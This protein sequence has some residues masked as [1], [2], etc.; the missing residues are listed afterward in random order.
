MASIPGVRF[1]ITGASGSQGLL[2]PKSSWRAYFLPRGGNASQDSAGTLIT[3]DSADVASRFTVNDWV[4]AGSLPANIRQVSVVDGNSMSVSGAAVTV[5]ENDRVFLIGLTQPTVTGGSATYTTPNTVIRERDDDAAGVFANSMITSDS[6]GLIQGFG[7]ASLYDVII[8]DGN[9]SHQGSIVDLEFGMVQGVS[10]VDPAIFGSTVTFLGN[11][12]G[13]STN[14]TSSFGDTATF[15]SIDAKNINTVIY[16]HK[17]ATG[18][19]GTV[20]DPWTGWDT[21]I[22]AGVSWS[23]I[24]VKFA[25][26][27]FQSDGGTLFSGEFITLEGSGQSNTIIFLNS[28]SATLFA[29]DDKTANRQH[30]KFADF[31]IKPTVGIST[32]SS[33]GIDMSGM[34]ESIVRDV[35]IDNMAIGILLDKLNNSGPCFYNHIET[36][37]F[38]SDEGSLWTGA[39]LLG[40]ANSNTF[41]RCRFSRSQ[42]IIGEDNDAHGP[43]DI[44]IDSCNF[45]GA[46]GTAIDISESEGLIR[47]KSC[48]FEN[49]SGSG[50]V[51]DDP[52]TTNLNN[53]VVIEDCYFTASLIDSNKAIVTVNRDHQSG[54]RHGVQSRGFGISP[55]GGLP[56]NANGGFEGW[57]SA[58]QA[59]YWTGVAGTDF[60]V[61]S[62]NQTQREGTIVHS[63]SFSVKSDDGAGNTDLVGIAGPAIPVDPTKSYT[64]SFWWYSVNKTGSGQMRTG[65]R[66]LN[67]SDVVI[68]TGTVWANEAKPLTYNAGR[69]AHLVGG[70]QVASAAATW[71]HF[72]ISY[73]LP[74]GVASVRPFVLTSGEDAGD[75]TIYVDDLIFAPG[76]VDFALGRENAPLPGSGS[77]TMYG[78]LRIAGSHLHSEPQSVASATELN[79]PSG[80]LFW[81]TG[82]SIITSI[83]STATISGREIT[84][85]VVDS[86]TFS[87]GNN[88]SL[89]GATA[90]LTTDDT[91]RLL[92]FGTTWSELT[93]SSN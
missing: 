39:K 68:T 48:R 55:Y 14:S 83:G 62:G 52:N 35:F 40:I 76:A 34:N 84:F 46:A 13:I 90:S 42:L 3:F 87:D 91:L 64:L 71:T 82:T 54:G 10:V 4:Q 60:D 89:S 28:A 24:H 30:Y 32:T 63:G 43:N 7:A 56:L 59:H 79:L 12:V 66:L 47:I 8:Q 74:D 86:C 78:D 1:D 70:D 67:S 92:C 61:A 6:N 50:I 65:L 93:R 72:S 2:S 31:S 88:L 36:C 11:I 19:I 27:S 51:V 20:G 17:Y 22:T 75:R 37:L 38:H 49:V 16:A 33:I 29:S 81:I 44:I 21:E 15:V 26:G 25:D 41:D 5:S 58:T 53:G 69:N 9:Q 18:G 57:I 23:D 80:E 77:Q 85:K 73:M 45:E